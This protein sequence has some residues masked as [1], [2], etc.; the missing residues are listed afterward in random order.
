MAREVGTPLV[1]VG[2]DTPVAL[3][4]SMAEQPLQ[5]DVWEGCARVLQAALPAQGGLTGL[6]ISGEPHKLCAVVSTDSAAT[7]QAVCAALPVR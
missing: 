2:V 1:A 4:W 6:A 3:A 7:Y 5:V